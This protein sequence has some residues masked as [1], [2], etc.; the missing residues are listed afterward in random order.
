LPPTARVV[1]WNFDSISIVTEAA[2]T[3]YNGV[4]ISV[5]IVF[6]VVM[7]RPATFNRHDT[8]RGS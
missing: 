6:A 1:G 8:C 5:G 3:G 7:T 2:A 4:G